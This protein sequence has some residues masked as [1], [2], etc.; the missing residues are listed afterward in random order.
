MITQ[1]LTA[2][3][4]RL[5]QR[6]SSRKEDEDS[7]DALHDAFC[8]LWVKK[9]SLDNQGRADGLLSVTA[10]NLRIDKLRRDNRFERMDDTAQLSIIQDDEDS[11]TQ[12]LYDEINRII[13]KVLT[14]RDREIFILRDRD[15]WEFEELAMKFGLSE[16]NI[17]MIISRA[18]KTV[19]TYYLNNRR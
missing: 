14:P 12:D 4:R 7:I 5:S 16:S 2:A 9:D 10:R 13:S 3:F 8:R 19:R 1:E 11:F 17:R 15:G 18:R 6:L